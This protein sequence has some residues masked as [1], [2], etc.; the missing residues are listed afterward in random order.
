MSSKETLSPDDY[1][2]VQIPRE[3]SRRKSFTIFSI[4]TLVYVFLIIL[5]TLA[6]PS[7]DMRFFSALTAAG[8]F[9]PLYLM[10]CYLAFKT[11]KTSQLKILTPD[12]ERKKQLKDIEEQRKNAKF[13]RNVVGIVSLLIAIACLASITEPDQD[14][15]SATFISIFLF[16]LS[17]YFLFPDMTK[18]AFSKGRSFLAS[19]F[20]YFWEKIGPT[21][22]GVLVLLAILLGIALFIFLADEIFSAVARVPVSVAVIVGALIIASAMNNK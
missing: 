3:K 4:S 20:Q 17:A 7:L 10:F 9:L 1:L 18:N 16:S 12:G 22:I 11:L 15:L 13:Y 19:T 14:S 2:T 6:D 5:M 21:V 8:L